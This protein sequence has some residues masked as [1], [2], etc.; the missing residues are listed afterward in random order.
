[1]KSFVSEK[2]LRGKGFTNK[3]EVFLKC[4]NF[5]TPLKKYLYINNFSGSSIVRIGQPI[6][7]EFRLL[8]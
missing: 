5:R 8:P 6:K 7:K 1:M 4:Q 2:Y 3:F